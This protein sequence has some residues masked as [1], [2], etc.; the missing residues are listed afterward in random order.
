M[1]RLHLPVAMAAPNS[2]SWC[3]SV[4]PRDAAAVTGN[5]TSRD[6]PATIAT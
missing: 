5:R 2:S 3:L 4:P 6:W 1:D